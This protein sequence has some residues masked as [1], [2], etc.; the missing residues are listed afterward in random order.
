MKPNWLTNVFCLWATASLLL[1][2]GCATAFVRS[3]STVEPEQVFPAT[4]FDAEFFWKAGVKGEP[5]FATADPKQKNHPVARIA[6][7]IGGMVDLP[8]SLVFDTLLLPV[9][10][11]RPRKE[12]GGGEAKPEN[13]R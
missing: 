7:G 3:S 9:D 4:A 11:S 10:L 2:C 6:Y 13:P 12:D 1:G 5:L 8:I